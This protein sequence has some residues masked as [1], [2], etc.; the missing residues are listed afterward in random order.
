MWI[1]A[2]ILFSSALAA[3]RSAP[4]DPP[5][6]RVATTRIPMRVLRFG[7]DA[8]YPVVEGRVGDHEVLFLVDTGSPGIGVSQRLAGFLPMEGRREV[9]L[10]VQTGKVK[11]VEFRLPDIVVGGVVLHGQD[12]TVIELL[13]RISLEM[14]IRI[15][16]L[17]GGPLF[18]AG[19]VTL[20]FVAGSLSVRPAGEADG[21]PGIVYIPVMI[22]EG[23]PWMEASVC[24]AGTD[25][26]ILDTGMGWALAVGPWSVLAGR[27]TNRGELPC[28][29]I[30]KDVDRLGS[31]AVV[32]AGKLRW[33]DVHIELIEQ[34]TQLENRIGSGL[35]A[36]SRLVVDYPRRRIGVQQIRS[37][38]RSGWGLG[39]RC[40]EGALTVWRVL[41]SGPAARAGVR[42]GDRVERI[43]D[44][45]APGSV[46]DFYECLEAHESVSLHLAR[47]S[48][49]LRCEMTRGAYLPP[50]EVGPSGR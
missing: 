23:V 14:G 35:F 7:E 18:H 22:N 30:G 32:Q 13:D 25:A 33:E 38:T 20:D 50:I 16:G 9:D 41:P 10:T 26:F 12:G 37:G 1:R 28:N 31:A 46:A 15:D 5:S 45:A 40:D 44:D 11:T 3:C 4:I 47:G 27:I 6:V 42:P 43:G 21:E 24:D 29:K 17:L 8:I 48:D 36:G 19:V 39:V 2:L 34:A 49:R